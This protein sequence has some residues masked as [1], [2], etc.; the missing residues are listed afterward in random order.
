MLNILEQIQKPKAFD[1]FIN[2]NMKTSTYRIGWDA[3]MD[4]EYEASKTYAAATAEY[5]AAMLGTV[6]SEGAARPKR[7]MPSIGELSGTIARMGDEWQIPNDRLERY[8]YMMNRLRDKAKNLTETQKNAQYQNLVRY[9]FNPYELAAVAPHRRIVAQYWEG[10]SDGQV[11]VAKT[12]NEGGVVW[13]TPL[14]NG[15]T[16]KL[17]PKGSTV[18]STA[19]LATMDVLATL[20]LLEDMADTAGKTVLKFRVSKST[21]ALISNST[22]LKS[23]IGMNLGRLKADTTPMLAIDTVNSYLSALQRPTIEVIDEKGVLNT[24]TSVNLFKDG[25]VVAQ[26]ADKVAVLKVSD[27]LETIDPVPNKTYTS[28]FDNLISQWRNDNGR[29]VA[30]EMFAYP[31]FTGKNDVFILDVTTAYT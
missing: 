19:T 3:E 7:D 10:L 5:A 8:Y 12:N 14:S 4:V 24:G 26:C 13:S 15:I 2:E 17:L 9:L 23:L 27:P 16:K 11:T 1:A 29:Y 21:A 18:W 6:I 31:V 30:Y 25:R 20:Q 22:Q 28:Y